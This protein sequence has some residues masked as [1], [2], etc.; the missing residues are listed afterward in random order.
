MVSDSK[1][2]AGDLR[3]NAF[4]GTDFFPKLT[5]E[6]RAVVEAHPADGARMILEGNAPLDLAAVVAYEHHRCHEAA[7]HRQQGKG[8]PTE[9]VSPCGAQLE[10]I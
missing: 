7:R 6:E 8:R 4:M 10:Q 3:P 9:P 1:R 5:P 2:I